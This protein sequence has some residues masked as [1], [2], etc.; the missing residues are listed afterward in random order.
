MS[1]DPVECDQSHRQNDGPFYNLA[2]EYLPKGRTSIQAWNNEIRIRI[3]YE[4]TN[5]LPITFLSE[6]IEL[7]E[8]SQYKLQK[9]VLEILTSVFV[10]KE[11]TFITA[12][13]FLENCSI[14][15]YLKVCKILGY[16]FV[17]ID[18]LDIK[19]IPTDSLKYEFNKMITDPEMATNDRLPSFNSFVEEH[20]TPF[21]MDAVWI[22]QMRNNNDENNKDSIWLDFI[23]RLCRGNITSKERPLPSIPKSV[24]LASIKDVVS[25]LDLGK[26]DSMKITES[27][28]SPKFKLQ[29]K[30]V[31]DRT[32]L[33]FTVDSFTTQ[34]EC[35]NGFSILSV[36]IK[37]FFDQIHSPSSVTKLTSNYN[38][39]SCLLSKQNEDSEKFSEVA[40][41]RKKYAKMFFSDDIIRSIWDVILRYDLSIQRSIGII[42]EVF[43]S[44]ISNFL[45]TNRDS[46]YPD[47]HIFIL[48]EILLDIFPKSIVNQSFIIFMDH[49][50]NILMNYKEYNTSNNANSINI[51][52]DIYKNYPW[53]ITEKKGF[54][55]VIGLPFFTLASFLINKGLFELNQYLKER[56]IEWDE[57]FWSE[58][59]TV[60]HIMKNIDE[61]SNNID[62]ND[63]F[64]PPKTLMIVD[65]IHKYYHLYFDLQITRIDEF[66]KDHELESLL[67][68]ILRNERIND[69]VNF[70][71]ISV[72][73]SELILPPSILFAN[74][75]FACHFTNECF[76]KEELDLYCESIISKNSEIIQELTDITGMPF[77]MINLSSNI[78]KKKVEI[79]IKD[80]KNKLRDG[81][82]Q[83]VPLLYKRFY[84][85]IEWIG[86]Y[87]KYYLFK[88]HPSC[89]PVLLELHWIFIKHFNQGNLSELF[90]TKESSST[91]GFKDPPELLFEV[92]SCMIFPAISLLPMSPSIP[93]MLSN[94]IFNEID[95]KYRYQIY[96]RLIVSSY[97]KYPM[98]YQWI[99]AK[100][101]LSKYLKGVTTDIVNRND[102][103]NPVYTKRRPPIQIRLLISNI[104]GLCYT[105]PLVV[106]DTVINQC[107][108]YDNMIPLL[109]EIFG[110]NMDEICFDV[111]IFTIINFILSRPIN[112]IDCRS[113]NS[114]LNCSR[115]GN[116]GISKFTA[117]LFTKRKIPRD[118]L[119]NF[120]QTIIY[121]IDET[122]NEKEYTTLISNNFLDL[123]FWRQFLET[124]LWT[125][126][127]DLTILTRKQIQCLA[128]GPL[129]FQLFI[130]QYEEVKFGI[131]DSQSF[132]NSILDNN[133]SPKQNN[134]MFISILRSGEIK[135]KDILFRISKLRS[136]LLWDAPSN[137][138]VDT[139]LLINLSDELHWCCIQN[140]EFLKRSFD[141][142]SYRDFVLDIS[143][144]KYCYKDVIIQTFLYLDIP[145]G[146][147]FLR[148]GIR[149]SCT[150]QTDTETSATEDGFMG[151]DSEALKCIRSYIAQEN[152]HKF[153]KNEFC[154]NLYIM[155][156]Y[157]DLC[158]ISFPYE[159]YSEKLFEIY[160]EIIDCKE[161]IDQILKQNICEHKTDATNKRHDPKYFLNPDN[162]NILPGYIKSKTPISKQLKDTIK[163]HEKRIRR[164]YS[165]YNALATEYIRHYKRYCFISEFTS[166]QNGIGWLETGLNKYFS[167][168]AQLEVGEDITQSFMI[169]IC[170]DFIAPRVIHSETDAIFSYLW[171]ER[172]VLNGERGIFS[173]SRSL[174]ES[175]L[176][177]LTKHISFLVRSSTPRESQLLGLFFNEIF[178]FIRR[179]SFD[180][181]QSIHINNNHHQETTS[182]TSHYNGA[183]NIE[184][185]RPETNVIV[186]NINKNL[187]IRDE[188]AIKAKGHSGTTE[189]K[190]ANSSELIEEQ[191]NGDQSIILDKETIHDTSY[192][193]H[194]KGS[195]KFDTVRERIDENSSAEIEN[196][197]RKYEHEEGS[198]RIIAESEFNLI[199]ECE[200]N[201]M[202]S[203]SL[204]LGLIPK[205]ISGNSLE[206][207]NTL[208]SVCM[209]S[210][211]Y[212]SFPISSLTGDYLIKKL[213]N[214]LEYVTNN[215]WNDLNLSIT[216]LILKLKQ[217]KVNWIGGS[218]GSDS[219]EQIGSVTCRSNVSNES[220]KKS[221][222]RSP[223]S[224]NTSSPLTNSDKKSESNS[225]RP[226][227]KRQRLC[228]NERN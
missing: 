73:L 195:D 194:N 31:R 206:W 37:Y 159:H 13:E 76:T 106:C 82:P 133:S 91:I 134:D 109:V 222:L 158:D 101:T 43:I 24:K 16:S 116:R 168:C 90:E 38:S 139:K 124:V 200:K 118:I 184:K 60:K 186:K 77:S 103:K 162:I 196:C 137:S 96:R 41:Q 22:I 141:S 180:L 213:P 63:V 132:F 107:N 36:L 121:R 62:Y 79:V 9:I 29:Q 136:E 78:L 7:I 170:K 193:S 89:I 111:M 23:A 3:Q 2:R 176:I 28:I 177:L 69:D 15:S 192:K 25:Y 84:L 187:E 182:A 105:N 211:L 126:M 227:F 208:S 17:G 59:K 160:S 127:L 214:I 119:K 218:N 205:R 153:Y 138:N 6:N 99:C 220:S 97:N 146:W 95:I 172:F 185:L 203:L 199:Y 8:Q 27:L 204:G 108:N 117:L 72:I 61:N 70:Q 50:S 135:C 92:S 88:K 94:S 1:S 129:L 175:F 123:C 216:S 65:K 83:N 104:I 191:I 110:N 55:D 225:T 143:N 152:S 14:V 56:L 93:E 114:D 26:L 145:T 219:F 171:I 51:G 34:R 221:T 49:I 224:V 85:L 74:S 226:E 20:I 45:V 54:K 167:E 98:N 53:I 197:I 75:L 19:E 86:K 140:I 125:P 39:E 164:L 122:F 155:F 46:S 223:I 11:I 212:E 150:P 210:R 198:K 4:L 115:F 128:G 151:I 188:I 181:K 12:I 165:C 173:S 209:L 58:F 215:H 202:I 120:L 228:T 166:S 10:Y 48:L 66:N 131:A 154:V 32:R 201:I 217:C 87:C 157:L 163:P 183:P 149:K 18:E 113:K 174:I 71:S 148:Y 67:K 190:N 47:C 178:S 112:N 142:D 130:S 44:N 179:Y 189:G 81:N 21:I 42:F 30:Y 80:I 147:S 57:V 156:W 161:K 5:I 40:D 35:L 64:L 169:W 207:V 52:G 144:T 68:E 102:N 33:C 100:K